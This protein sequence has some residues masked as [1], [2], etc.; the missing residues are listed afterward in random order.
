[1]V[2]EPKVKALEEELHKDKTELVSLKLTCLHALIKT[3]DNCKKLK[4]QVDYLLKKHYQ[5]SPKEEKILK[6]Y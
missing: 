2:L 4:N 5:I 1:M 6:L 3:C